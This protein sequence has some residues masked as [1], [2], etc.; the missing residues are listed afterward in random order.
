M[1]WA[2]RVGD[3]AANIALVAINLVRI[4]TLAV[5]LLA[6]QID[7]LI[8]RLAE[9]SESGISRVQPEGLRGWMR[10]FASVPLLAIAGA[11]RALSIITV[12]VRQVAVTIDEFFRI[13]AEGEGA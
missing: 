6:E 13:L 10:L 4:V 11:L 9:L 7:R 1:T 3:L 5:R 2:E 12:L 8:T